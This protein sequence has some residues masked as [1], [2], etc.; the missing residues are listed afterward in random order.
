MARVKA[1]A[2]GGAAAAEAENY[3]PELVTDDEPR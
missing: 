1:L 3:R 2:A